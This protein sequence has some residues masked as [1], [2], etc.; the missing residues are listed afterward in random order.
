MDMLQIIMTLN[1]YTLML[2]VD[3]LKQEQGYL[4]ARET[5]ILE[6]IQQSQRLA[7]S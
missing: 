7:Q 2:R 4:Q 1:N 6:T 3:L 5:L